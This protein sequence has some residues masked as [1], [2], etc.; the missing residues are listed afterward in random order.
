LSIISKRDRTFIV[1]FLPKIIFKI[2]RIWSKSFAKTL[3]ET[4]W[5]GGKVWGKIKCYAL[6]Y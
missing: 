4:V 6:K 2:L 5:G 3:G 1:N